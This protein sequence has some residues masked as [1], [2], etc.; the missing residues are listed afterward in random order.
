MPGGLSRGQ[1]H[2]LS[3]TALPSAT[4]STPSGYSDAVSREQRRVMRD[5]QQLNASSVLLT[6]S[7]ED[8]KRLRDKARLIR[9]RRSSQ[10]STHFEETGFSEQGLS[11]L[12][13]LQSPYGWPDREASSVLRRRVHTDLDASLRSLPVCSSEV[14]AARRKINRRRPSKVLIRKSFEY[15]SATPIGRVPDGYGRRVLTS[16]PLDFGD[17]WYGEDIAQQAHAP[18]RANACDDGP[19][20]AERLGIAEGLRQIRELLERTEWAMEEQTGRRPVVE[21]AVQTDA[22]GNRSEVGVQA[23]LAGND[24]LV[25]VMRK[26]DYEGKVEASEPSSCPASTTATNS[27]SVSLI[28]SEAV[29]PLVEVNSPPME[30]QVA[31]R[32]DKTGPMT[33]CF[34]GVCELLSIWRGPRRR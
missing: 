2:S 24:G 6:Q 17:A 20:R 11:P 29:S 14:A 23:D 31:T 1:P 21:A 25:S 28:H 4:L 10:L 18:G 12:G 7:I 22:N 8:I 33:D 13:T 30:A 34:R 27:A 9:N 3:C 15:A 5:R 26:Q 32:G 19:P 16:T